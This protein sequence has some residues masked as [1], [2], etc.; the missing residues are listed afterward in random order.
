M[1]SIGPPSGAE[2]ASDN[3]DRGCGNQVASQAEICA[4]TRRPR[5]ASV[6]SQEA[7]AGRGPHGLGVPCIMFNRMAG[8]AGIDMRVHPHGLRH[9]IACGSVLE[10]VPVSII[11]RQL[12]PETDLSSVLVLPIIL[13]MRGRSATGT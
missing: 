13:A 8:R 2:I 10:G 12:G 6:G 1:Y 9:T 7:A 11:Q 5:S 3:R 4:V